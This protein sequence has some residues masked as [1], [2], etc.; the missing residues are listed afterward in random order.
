MD[1]AIGL[2]LAAA[3]FLA[4][5]DIFGRP[6][7]R[8]TDPIW[9]TA[10]TAVAGEAVLGLFCLFNGDFRDPW[11]GWRA[12]A[13]IAAAGLL[14]VTLARSVLFAGIKHIGAS[15]ASSLAAANVFF[16]MCLGMVFLGEV[17]TEAVFV[18]SVAIVA[19]CVFITRSHPDTGEA[20]GKRR[21]ILG[22]ALALGSA[23]AFGASSVFVRPVIHGF[24]SPVLAS[25]YANTFGILGFVPYG[26]TRPLSGEVKQW[27]RQTAGLF[28]L[29]GLAAA[30][31]TIANYAAF[32]YAP[33]LF[34]QPLLQ[35]RPFFVVVISRLF[36]QVHERVNWKV[37]VG[38]A[39]VV[40][41]TVLLIRA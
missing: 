7:L 6:A 24:A 32:K 20:G 31:G 27:S 35:T 30:V 14:R 9:G 40:A 25:F 29:S 41:G 1:G 21:V 2:G 3:F 15:R 12:L 26:V 18:A 38:A 16:A 28:A 37:A 11:P 5:R 19:G 22:S 13:G 23:A 33:V 39:L 10:A 8:G 17:L 36:F 4:L 34:V